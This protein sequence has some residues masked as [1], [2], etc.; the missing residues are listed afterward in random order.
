MAGRDRFRGGTGEG[1]GGLGHAIA[2]RADGLGRGR[3]A[4]AAGAGTGDNA[5]YTAA[6]QRW[7]GL[8]MT[9]SNCHLV[10]QCHG[11]RHMIATAPT[12]IMHQG[13]IM[14]CGMY[15]G[16]GTIMR[17]RRRHTGQHQRGHDNEIFEQVDHGISFTTPG[18][19]FKTGAG[20]FP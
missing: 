11:H 7:S 13:V 4:G 8:A 3:G 2:G 15:C 1:R 10:R 9:G 19:E 16:G 12:V 14:H 5:S 6:I 18:T 20:Q 17:H